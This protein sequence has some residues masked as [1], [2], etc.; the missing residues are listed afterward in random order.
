[1]ANQHYNENSKFFILIFF[2]LKVKEINRFRVQEPTWMMN[3]KKGWCVFQMH[4]ITKVHV[5]HFLFSITSGNLCSVNLNY[6]IPYSFIIF[7]MLYC[8]FGV[9]QPV[10]QIMINKSAKSNPKLNW[11]VEQISKQQRRVIIM[12]SL[13]SILLFFCYAVVAMYSAKRMAM[14]CSF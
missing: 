7:Y 1:M 5:D 11:Y 12:R 2:N 6:H 13:F 10:G 8:I 14:A 3:F 4:G 9:V